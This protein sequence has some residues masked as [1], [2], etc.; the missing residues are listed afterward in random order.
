[1]KLTDISKGPRH[2]EL[3]SFALMPTDIPRLL[4]IGETGIGKSSFC[5][6]MGGIYYKLTGYDDD[7]DSDSS[8]DEDETPGKEKKI[9]IV[10]EGQQEIFGTGTDQYSITQTTSWAQVKSGNINKL[11]Y[12]FCFRSFV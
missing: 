8:D 7:S 2:T 12:L 10:C 5:N 11:G 9:D 1:M 4:I 3:K 6:K